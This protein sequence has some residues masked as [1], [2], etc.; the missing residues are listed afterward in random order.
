[1]LDEF[2]ALR[3]QAIILLGQF[4]VLQSWLDVVDPVQSS[5]PY[6]GAGSEQLRE[7]VCLPPP[8][9]TVQDPHEAQAFQ[10]PLT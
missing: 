1:M 6:W 7:R 3:I 9:V 2:Y 10:F 8:Q 5:P 4:C